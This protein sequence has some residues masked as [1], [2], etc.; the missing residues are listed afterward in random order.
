[1][2]PLEHTDLKDIW[3]EEKP[4]FLLNTALLPIRQVIR[5]IQK[6]N[7]RG[8]LPIEIWCM[9]VNEY[10]KSCKPDYKSVQ[11]ISITSSPGKQVIHCRGVDVDMERFED[12]ANVIE[13]DK[14]LEFPGL[15]EDSN[16]DTVS[17]T[18]TLYD[19]VFLESS[20]SALRMPKCLFSRVSV[21]DVIAFLLGGECWLC[22]KER[23]ICPGCTGWFAQKFDAFMDCG[24][25]LACPLCMGLEFMA[26]DEEYQE[27][28]YRTEP[29]SEEEAARDKRFR[30]RLI[31]L[32][33]LQQWEAL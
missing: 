13:V 4:I 3:L 11:P 8:N 26:I 10:M 19:I 6:D 24:V 20:T 23:G 1:M 25:S 33:Y 15:Y 16:R 17:D 18:A 2:Y 21:P 22:E 5:Q 31:E 27:K 29:P 14:W 12:E 7:V 30:N 9:I 28:Y 32:G